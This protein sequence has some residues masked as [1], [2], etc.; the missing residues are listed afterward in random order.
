MVICSGRLA[1]LSW[2]LVSLG[3]N[4]VKD[5]AHAWLSL[6]THGLLGNI[7]VNDTWTAAAVLFLELL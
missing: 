7:I 2:P 6:L 5:G 3:L 1:R 4:L